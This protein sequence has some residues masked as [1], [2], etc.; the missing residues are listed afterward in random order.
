M[1]QAQPAYECPNSKCK[2]ANLV[3]VG[4]DPKNKN[5]NSEPQLIYQCKECGWKVG[6]ISLERRLTK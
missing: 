4:R 6:E 2:S 5:R 1:S 3:V